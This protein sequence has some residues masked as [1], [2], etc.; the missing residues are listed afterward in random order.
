METKERKGDKYPIGT[1]VKIKEDM[2]F[3]EGAGK[4]KTV[5]GHCMFCYKPIG[6]RLDNIMDELWIESDFVK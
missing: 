1:K 5:T 3:G 4:T 6:Y 2:G